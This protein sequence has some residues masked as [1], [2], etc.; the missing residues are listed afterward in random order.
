MKY[1][2]EEVCKE[3][4]TQE[5]GKVREEREREKEGREGKTS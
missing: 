4:L 5:M 1:D 2:E 3:L